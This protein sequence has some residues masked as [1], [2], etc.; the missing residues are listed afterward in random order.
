[1]DFSELSPMF[2]APT[3]SSDLSEDTNVPI[4]PTALPERP[5][6][7]HN[8]GEDPLFFFSRDENGK[9]IWPELVQYVASHFTPRVGCLVRLPVHFFSN[10]LLTAVN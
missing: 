10:I 2:R 8:I 1:M 4:G 3:P 5:P 9:L 6:Y 7:L